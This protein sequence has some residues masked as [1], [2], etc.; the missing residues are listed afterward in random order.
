MMDG[1]TTSHRFSNQNLRKLIVPLFIEHLMIVLVGI[2]DVFMVSFAGEAAVSGVTLVNMFVTFFIYVF[3]SLASGGAVIIS[4]YLGR[5][6]QDRAELAAGQLLALSVLVSA[7]CAFAVLAW[8]HSILNVLFGRVDKDVM[9]AC[10]TYQRIMAISFVPLGIYNSGAAI[11]RCISRTD[12]T[13][14]FSAAAN[15]INVLGN[16]LGIFVLKAGVAGVAW[17]SVAALSFSA[18]AVT[19]F[20]MR[21][22]NIIRY[23]KKN[24]LRFRRE[25]LGKILSV[26]LPNSLEN[27]LFQLVKVALSSITAMFGTVQI[28]ANGIAQTIWS[29]SALMVVAMGPVFITVIGQCMGAGE[30]GE[31]DYYFRKL[32]KISL[33]AALGWN[34]LVFALTPMIMRFFPLSADIRDLVIELVLIHNIF[35][36]LAWPFG[37]ALPNGL[38]AA[39]DV[40]FAMMVTIASTLL[41]RLFLSVAFGIWLDMGVIGIAWAMVCDWIARAIAFAIRYRQGKW[42]NMR[43]V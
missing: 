30:A 19:M 41:V 9:Q 5:K 11:C 3:A 38:R 42:R 16:A 33:A 32:M 18:A 27:G 22:E 34:I 13:L 40:R 24:I 1:M 39:G 2:A 37:G 7:L 21:D 8:N 20:C 6:D 12:I 4:Q 17:A 25:S 31:A 14:R 10:A 29:L 43:L 28:A 36:G 26:A 15:V 23:R 35:N